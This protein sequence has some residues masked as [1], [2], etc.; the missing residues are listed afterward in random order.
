MQVYPAPDDRVEVVYERFATGEADWLAGADTI[1]DDKGLRSELHS[2]VLFE[3]LKTQ[4][5][6]YIDCVP[7][8]DGAS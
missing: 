4:G 5:I 3:P 6:A 7:G 1:C 2:T 8:G